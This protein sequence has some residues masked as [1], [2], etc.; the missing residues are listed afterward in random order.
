MSGINADTN[1][2]ELVSS[3][4]AA[5]SVSNPIHNVITSNAQSAAAV[6]TAIGRGSS[7]QTPLRG[8]NHDCGPRPRV[9]QP[10]PHP[11]SATAGVSSNPRGAVS[12]AVQFGSMVNEPMFNDI[13]RNIASSSAI[14]PLSTAAVR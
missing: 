2:S 7:A 8:G 10:P 9:E 14:P 6:S 3:T 12:N 11:Q 13:N 1:V 5:G 4:V